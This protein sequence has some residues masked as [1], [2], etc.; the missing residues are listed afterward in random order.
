MYRIA[1]FIIVLSVQEE[2]VQAGE[3]GPGVPQQVHADPGHLRPQW[4]GRDQA[5]QGRRA[6]DGGRGEAG[7][8]QRRG[9]AHP[10]EPHR[11][12]GGR[13]QEAEL[14]TVRG[15]RGEDRGAG[16][17]GPRRGSDPATVNKEIKVLNLT[18]IQ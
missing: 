10:G 18:I 1:N 13:T 6:R 12:G 14:R 15:H 4:Q 3:G 7:R 11:G 17:R 16:A 5:L 8:L 2:C 9:G